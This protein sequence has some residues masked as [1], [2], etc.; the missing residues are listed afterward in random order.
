MWITVID[1]IV[2]EIKTEKCLKYLFIKSFKN[3]NKP[4]T[5]YHN[6]FYEK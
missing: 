5:C 4:T 6:F 1:I 3:Y 2:L